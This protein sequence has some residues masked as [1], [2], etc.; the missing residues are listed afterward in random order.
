MINRRHMVAGSLTAFG[1]A[2][3]LAQVPQPAPRK[4]Q[5]WGVH[6]VTWFGDSYE[7][8]R[9]RSTE[10]DWFYASAIDPVISRTSAPLA[11]M[12]ESRMD[13]AVGFFEADPKDF[14]TLRIEQPMAFGALRSLSGYD[15]KGERKM[16]GILDTSSIVGS[17]V[18]V[19]ATIGETDNEYQATITAASR[20]GLEPAWVQVDNVNGSPRFNT[21]FRR[22]IDVWEAHHGVRP[23]DLTALTNAGIEKGFR[24]ARMAPYFDG[25]ELRFAV[26]LRPWGNRGW[27]ARFG[28]ASPDAKDSQL[29]AKG[30]SL[31]QATQYRIGSKQA[32]ACIWQNQTGV[33]PNL[34][35]GV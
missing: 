14:E 19:K 29:R 33:K 9:D 13:A 23:E 17:R 1:F 4:S 30:Y 35:W 27:E 28:L 34:F 21:L 5:F 3:A 6:D 18:V 12:I 31:I 24:V 26:I 10:N 7:G 32:W 11:A 8:M 22:S 20:N 16:M 15:V 25:T 2:P